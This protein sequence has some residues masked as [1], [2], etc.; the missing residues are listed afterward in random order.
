MAKEML[1]PLFDCL[2]CNSRNYLN[3]P[4]QA[5]IMKITQIRKIKVQT[6]PC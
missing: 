1:F 5:V 3:L 4:N 6:I 2:N